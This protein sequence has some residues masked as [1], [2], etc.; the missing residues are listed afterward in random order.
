MKRRVRITKKEIEALQNDNLVNETIR[1]VR[2]RASLTLYDA[3]RLIRV[4]QKTGQKSITVNY[5]NRDEAYDSK[6]QYHQY[7]L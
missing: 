1:Q 2:I 3:V 6:P 5:K 7:R 4:Y